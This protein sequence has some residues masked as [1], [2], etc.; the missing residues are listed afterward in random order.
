MILIL[1]SLLAVSAAQVTSL[2][3]KMVQAYWADTQ[4]FE[5]AE[6]RLRTMERQL[7]ERAMLE[8]CPVLDAAP[9]PAWTGHR[10]A[11]TGR[12]GH[13]ALAAF[14]PGSGAQG[15][16]QAG[17]AIDTAQCMYYT[18]SSADNDARDDSD[19]RAWAVVQSIFV[20]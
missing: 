7:H 17:S 12:A 9:T 5:A 15:S 18:I 11:A 16:L 13:I 1:L 8:D 19:A 3:E 10:T 4:A 14:D 6:E 20:P 2:Q